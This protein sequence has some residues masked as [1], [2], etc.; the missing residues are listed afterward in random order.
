MEM[1]I[2]LPEV[3][4]LEPFQL[5]P[6]EITHLPFE[7]F[8]EL[9]TDWADKSYY[10]KADPVFAIRRDLEYEPSDK[11][12]QNLIML[13]YYAILLGSGNEYP[14]PMLSITY[15]QDEDHRIWRYAGAADRSF[16]LHNNHEC[17]ISHFQASH[18]QE[19]YALC[20]KTAVQ[21]NAPIFLLLNILGDIYSQ[22]VS[23][24]YASLPLMV[25][26]E[27][28]LIGTE[29]N[30]KIISRM[31]DTVNNKLIIDASTSIREIYSWRS[32]ILHGRK[33]KFTN[34]DRIF[35]QLK[36]LCYALTIQALKEQGEQNDSI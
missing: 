8:S 1:I 19:I 25:A 35:L 13:I 31:I 34:A 20:Q 26:L 27:S 6:Y 22:N 3:R 16:I 28:Y 4:I 21:W 7:T 24:Q 14:N 33:T 12:R 5:H 23:Q 30:A 2:H 10:E 18:I 11:V 17:T 9:D 36:D 29:P 15:F 32:D